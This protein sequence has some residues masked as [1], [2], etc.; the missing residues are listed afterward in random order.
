MPTLDALRAASETNLER[1]LAKLD[2]QHRAILRAAIEKYGRVQDIPQAV[3]DEMQRDTERATIGAIIL[4][5]HAADEWTTDQIVRQGV[6]VGRAG[7]VDYTLDAARRSQE[8]AAGTISTIRNRLARKVEDAAL[9]GPGN[10]GELTGDGIEQALDDVLTPAR[11]KTI[12]TDQTTGGF[13]TGQQGAAGRAEDAIGNDGA[14]AGL[15]QKVT[16]ALLWRTENDN[17]VCPRCSP[18]EGKPEEVWSLVFPE[19]PGPDAHPNC[20]LPGNDICCFGE[21]SLATDSVFDGPCIEIALASGRRLT[22]TE[23]HRILT[24]RGWMPAKLVAQSDY[25][26]ST[27]DP[28]RMAAAI[29]PNTNNRPARAEQVASSIDM[30][31]GMATAS[32]PPSPEYFD[33]DATFMDGQINVVY[34]NRKLGFGGNPTGLQHSLQR[35]LKWRSSV[36]SGSRSQSLFSIADD[37]PNCCGVCGSHLVVASGGLHS[38]PFNRLGFAL[39]A[40]LHA[41]VCKNARYGEAA[42]AIRLGQLIDRFSSQVSLDRVVSVR[43]FFFRGHVYDYSV[44]NTQAFSV[45]GIVTHNCRCWLE[46][47]VVAAIE[48]SDE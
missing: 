13:S 37:T 14:A 4:L 42:D 18:L 2:R 22:V 36:G 12:A 30:P 31:H 34:P 35:L 6:A 38:R 48:D 9:T 33:G 28:E 17:L 40:K 8:M 15:G 20:V 7:A 39:P 11:R 23:N 3:W 21:I 29:N 47:K 41:A 43:K 46:P 44:A 45:N 19:G 16:I 25:C 32:M 24:W 27:L 10:T 1:A 26:F 5:M